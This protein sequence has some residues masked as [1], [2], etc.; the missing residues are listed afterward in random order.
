MQA[1][2]GF[3]DIEAN[4]VGV[5]V[6]QLSV[7]YNIKESPYEDSPFNCTRNVTETGFEDLEVF[8]CCRFNYK[9]EENFKLHEH[10]LHII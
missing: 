1:S 8:F 2:S 4:G 7:C 6:V 3:V 9:I 10:S 5:G